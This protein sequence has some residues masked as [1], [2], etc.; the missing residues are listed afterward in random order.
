VSYYH[1]V[2]GNNYQYDKEDE[3]VTWP[4]PP[5]PERVRREPEKRD[6]DLSDWRLWAHREPGHC[7]CG[8]VRADCEY[9]R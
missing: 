5:P 9:H 4:C 3:P 6:V 2:H 1:P 8:I 7:P